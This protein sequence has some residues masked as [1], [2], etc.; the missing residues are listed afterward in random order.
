MKTVIHEMTNIV[1]GIN[2]RLDTTEEKVLN[3]IHQD[4]NY[5]NR[6]TEAD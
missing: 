6:R 1:Y 4:R 3:L 2:R 5:S